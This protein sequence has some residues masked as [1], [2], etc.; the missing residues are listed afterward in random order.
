MWTICHVKADLLGLVYNAEALSCFLKTNRFGLPPNVGFL[1]CDQLFSQ[2]MNEV[3]F[4]DYI[5]QIC[6]STKFCGQ[7]CPERERADSV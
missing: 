4:Q 2:L 7:A 6:F 3:K 5:I 1:N